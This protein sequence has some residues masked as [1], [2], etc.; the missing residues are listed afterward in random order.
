MVV[1]IIVINI[2]IIIIFVMG[3][4]GGFYST[5]VQTGLSGVWERFKRIRGSF[6]AVGFTICFLWNF[7][8]E[9]LVLERKRNDKTAHPYL[10]TV[11]S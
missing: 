7:V 4:G 8:I 1:F 6:L 9:S 10:K 3:K 11:P 2:N 5:G